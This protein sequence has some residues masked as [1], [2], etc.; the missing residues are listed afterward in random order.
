MSDGLIHREGVTASFWDR[1]PPGVV[2]GSGGRVTHAERF[3]EIVRNAGR[4]D[5]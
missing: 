3:S 1:V 5:P 2:D 4:T